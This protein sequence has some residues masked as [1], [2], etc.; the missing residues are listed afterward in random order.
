MPAK[1]YQPVRSKSQSRALFALAAKGKLPL[2]EAK[3]KTKAAAW[4]KLP[5]KVKRKK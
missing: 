5:E 2:A 4:S 3:G 1:K